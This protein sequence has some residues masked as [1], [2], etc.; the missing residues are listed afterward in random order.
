MKSKHTTLKFVIVNVVIAIILL[1]IVGL[2]TLNWLGRYTQH[3][4]SIAVP[5]FQSLT[6]E[7]AQRL[8]MERN[9]QVTVIDSAYDDGAEPGVVLEQ[10]PTIGNRVKE[11]RM[12]YLTVNSSK[13]KLIP[14]PQLNNSPYRQC[15]QVLR[16]H[17]FT[18]GK[19]S[20]APS[21]FKNLVL[22]LQING[23]NIKADTLLRN[24]TTIDLVLG[25]GNNKNNLVPLPAV[26]GM[27]LNHAENTLKENYLNTFKVIP[28][29]SITG[30]GHLNRLTAIVYRQTPEPEEEQLVEAGS[31]ITLYVTQDENRLQALDS[32]INLHNFQ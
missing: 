9:L 20:Y 27:K 17:G 13:P 6:L 30:R 22:N 19:I 14:F 2:L 5:A 26:V 1:V 32:L 31:Y 28:D 16:S 24:G 29:N 4:Q 18:V 7:S 8:A 3:G 10:Y 15:M 23:E 12:I 11:K 25:D 21:S